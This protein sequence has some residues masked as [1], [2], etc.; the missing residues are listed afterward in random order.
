MNPIPLVSF[1]GR[2]TPDKVMDMVTTLGS[3]AAPAGIYVNSPGGRFEFFSVMG[4]AIARRGIVTL[5]GEVASAG[6]ILSL[7]G[8]HRFA[9]P[10]ST[11]FFHEVRSIVSDQAVLIC[12]IEEALEH[13]ERMCAEMREGYE[14]WLHSLRLA[15]Q[16]FVDFISQQ[17]GV[18]AAVILDLMRQEATL[19]AREAVRYGIIHEILPER[20][21]PEFERR[22]V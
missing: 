15:Q 14:E 11:F 8:H 3:S 4:P 2:I 16:W 18:S 1:Q 10:D 5:S 6:V 20:L 9:F 13:Q 7:L 21:R 19:S 22:L 12:N 17:I